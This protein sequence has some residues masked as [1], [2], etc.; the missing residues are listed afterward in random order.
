M[1]V[2]ILN[3]FLEILGGQ[4]PSVTDKCLANRNVSM[5]DELEIV[6]EDLLAVLR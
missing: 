2:G 5:V 3:Q 1:V 4:G 6:T